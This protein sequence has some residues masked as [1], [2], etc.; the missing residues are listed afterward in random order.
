MLKG[1]GH[2]RHWP[3]P[4]WMLVLS[5]VLL[6]LGV[7]IAVFDWNWVKGPIERRVA[8]ATGREF[9]IGDLDGDLGSVL[10]LRVR[11]ARLANAKWA[12]EPNMVSV[13]HA[14]IGIALWPLLRGEVFLPR[15]RLQR[16]RVWLERRADGVANWQFE[17]RRREPAGAARAPDIGRLTVADGQFA[18]S[19]PVLKTQLRVRVNSG[20]GSPG[21]PSPLIVEGSGRYRDGDFDLRG[22]I[23]SPLQLLDRKKPYRVDVRARAGATLAHAH[24]ALRNAVQPS[25]FAVDFALSG[26]DLEDLYPLAGLALPETP[27]YELEGRLVRNGDVLAYRNFRGTMGDSDLSGNVILDLGGARPVMRGNVVSR[28]LDLDDLAGMIGG[29]PQTGEGERASEEQ[30]ARAAARAA[31]PTVLPDRSFNLE[32]LRAMDADVT[33]RAESVNAPKLPI[34]SMQAHVRLEDGELVV[35]PLRFAVAGGTLSGEI[36]LDASNDPITATTDMDV[37]GLNLRRV[38]PKIRQDSTGKISGK[39]KLAGAGNSVARMLAGADGNVDL[40]MGP[41]RVSNLLVELAGLDVAEALRYA[42]GKDKMIGMRCAYAQ[43]A[44]DE[45]TM[46]SR[47]LVFDTTDTAFVGEGRIDLGKERLD[48]DLRPQPKDTSPLAL[49]VPLEIGGT[50][51]DPSIQ[52]KTGP[53]VARAAAAAALYALAPPAALLALIETGPGENERCGEALALAREG[54][55]AGKDSLAGKEQPRRRNPGP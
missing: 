53:L 37:R 16:P 21:M 34:E 32:K 18:L 1:P 29:T 40:V 2:W 7:L 10:H 3:P 9:T 35:E 49:R 20:E 6:A 15:V 43:F 54:L 19:E 11:D 30:R 51:K 42:V 31:S 26:E 12:A 45:G 36:T 33:V 48:L 5:A 39:L 17:G 13:E 8:A 46:T 25:D 14:D 50:F 38:F 41:G 55:P 27:P 22:T 4:R 24:G 52:P 44:L 28:R 47:S 23:D